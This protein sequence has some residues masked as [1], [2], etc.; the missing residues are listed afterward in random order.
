[1][2]QFQERDKLPQQQRKVLDYIEEYLEISGYPP[3]IAEISDFLGVSS[4]FGVRKHLDALMKK[5]FLVRGGPG[6]SRALMVARPSMKVGGE[7]HSNAIP[8]IGRV[9]AGEPI[10]AVENVEG[11]LSFKPMDLSRKVFGLRVKGE[12]MKDRGI[13]DGD[14]VIVRQQPNADDGDIV[15]ARL[16][17]TA[18]VKTFRQSLDGYFLEPANEKFRPIP[19]TPDLDFQIL[20]KVTSVIRSLDEKRPGVF[21][22][23]FH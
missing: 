17:D 18:T 5:G 8:V 19:I 12:S 6:L 2:A 4:T 9:T 22:L 7:R 20:G 23:K 21:Q 13:L 3:S 1:M 16:E 14:L 10:L 15:V 11:W